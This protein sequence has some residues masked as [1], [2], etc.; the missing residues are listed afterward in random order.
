S[1]PNSRKSAS[2]TKFKIAGRTATT[3]A[4]RGNRS[5]TDSSPAIAPRPRKARMRS[6]PRD[7]ITTLRRPSRTRVA[8][9][10]G[11]KQHFVGLEPHRRRT[12]EKAPK[13]LFGQA[14]QQALICRPYRRL[15]ADQL[16]TASLGR[17]T[18]S[19]LV[20]YHGHYTERRTTKPAVSPDAVSGSA[21]SWHRQGSSNRRRRV[22]GA[23]PLGR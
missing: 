5:M 22:A 17:A 15:L 18:W 13:E 21:C 10:A 11:T 23:S 6:L 19:E 14:R 1:L 16:G 20:A 2:L 4:E 9:I 12:A 8:G 7:I 3:D